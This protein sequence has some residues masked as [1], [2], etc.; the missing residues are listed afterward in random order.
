MND[1]IDRD[2]AE[3]GERMARVETQLEGL[4]R[5]FR[6][7]ELADERRHVETRDGLA[8]ID[9]H[10]QRLTGRVDADAGHKVPLWQRDAFGGMTIREATVLL[11]TLTCAAGLASQFLR[12]ETVTPSELQQL[13]ELV[14]GMDAAADTDGA[15]P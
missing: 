11:S 6:E 15:A 5:Q 3:M 13:H 10:L 14:E 9:A 8:R 2:V 12:G 4:A 7:H 1:S